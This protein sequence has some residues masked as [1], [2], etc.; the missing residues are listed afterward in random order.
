M[1]KATFGAGCF[2][3]VEA[4]FRE[5]AGVLDTA[6]GYSGGTLDEPTYQDVC[7]GT[8]GHAEVVQ[9]KLAHR[10]RV[11]AGLPK[12]LGHRRYAR[13]QRNAVGAR[14]FTE[15]R[16]LRFREHIARWVCG[17]GDANGP[18]LVGDMDS[19]KIDM[20]FKKPV[21]QKFNL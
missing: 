11:V 17:P 14:Q 4:A 12:R 19:V 10:V 5:V 7:T 3:G 9:V 8:T 15:M 20:I 16:D 13:V 18:S 6:V 1:E 2:W 21:V